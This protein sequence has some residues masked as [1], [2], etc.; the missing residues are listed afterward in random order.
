M[1]FLTI[2]T[3][4]TKQTINNWK[5]N[6]NCAQSSQVCNVL[7]MIAMKERVTSWI[8]IYITTYIMSYGYTHVPPQ[9]TN[10]QILTNQLNNHLIYHAHLDSTH[11]DSLLFP[12][13][14]N[15]SKISFRFSSNFCILH[16]TISISISLSIAHTQ[17]SHR[18]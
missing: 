5:T 11:L 12:I 13:V 2:F 10:Q 3:T 17:F 15:F 16:S 1:H 6:W 4:K 7:I 9:P 8:S 18:F 14:N